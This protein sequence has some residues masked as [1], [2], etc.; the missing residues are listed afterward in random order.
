[1]T[2]TKRKRDIVDIYDSIKNR[3]RDVGNQAEADELERVFY[4][5]DWPGFPSV[6]GFI[7]AW[8]TKDLVQPPGCSVC[9]WRGE[10]EIKVGGAH[11]WEPEILSTTRAGVLSMM[12]IHFSGAIR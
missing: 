5:F 12:I 8:K 1:M 7:K 11:Y 4:E 6:T 2:K 9:F 3:I 10:Y